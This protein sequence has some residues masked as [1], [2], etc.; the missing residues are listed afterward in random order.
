MINENDIKKVKGLGFLQDKTKEGYFNGRVITINGILSTNELFAV[1]ECANKYGNG[2]VAF[3]SRMTLEIQGIHYDNINL[4]IEYLKGY[5]L[6]FGGTGDKVRPLTACKGATCVFGQINSA[7]ITKRLHELYYDGYRSVELPHKF[8][9]AVGGCPNNCIKPDLNDVG[10]IGQ[11]KPEINKNLCKACKKCQVMECCQMKGSFKDES[12]KLEFD[13]NKCNKCGKCINKCPFK[14]INS[15]C[16]GVKILIGG[17]WGRVGRPGSDLGD[18]YSIEEAILIVEKCILAFK[19]FA[20]KKERFGD[21]IDRIGFNK[22]RD[23]I[24]SNEPL[25]R[26]E[27]IINMPFNQKEA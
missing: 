3:T 9:M 8:K 11:N 1:S 21:M 13:Y 2:K 6:S 26:K 18:V 16:S 12:G 7:D 23:F 19:Y 5:G 14:A 24:L 27:E 10:L 20:Y 4:A 15:S 22:V 25:E 17:K